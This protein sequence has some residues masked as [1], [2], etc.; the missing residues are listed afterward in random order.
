MSSG[1]TNISGKSDVEGFGDVLKLIAEAK[2]HLNDDAKEFLS[3]V[4]D[5]INEIIK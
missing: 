3:Q 4:R 1:I 2:P 5:S